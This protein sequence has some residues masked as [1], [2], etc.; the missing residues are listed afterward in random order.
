MDSVSLR[1]IESIVQLSLDLLVVRMF[2][3]RLNVLKR[4]RLLWLLL[5]PRKKEINR[6]LLVDLSNRILLLDSLIQIVSSLVLLSLLVDEL[7][8]NM[9]SSC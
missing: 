5:D 9:L 8:H 1:T 2:I 7:L 4:S 3:E 6:A